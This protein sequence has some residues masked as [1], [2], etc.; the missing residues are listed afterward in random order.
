M[1]DDD[2]LMAEQIGFQRQEIDGLKR[3]LGD[4]VNRANKMKW[5]KWWI[6][7][8][9]A[10]VVLFLFSLIGSL[11]YMQ[12]TTDPTPTHCQI[13]GIEDGFYTLRGI[14][15]WHIDIRYGRFCNIEDARIAAEQLQC[16]VRSER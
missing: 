1:Q 16:T 6:S 5:E 10:V 13:D 9:M 14:I 12:F 15:P 4:E 2:R 3:R 8:T 7:F 11:L